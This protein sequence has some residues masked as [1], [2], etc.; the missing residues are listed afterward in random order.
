MTGRRIVRAL[1]AGGLL[2]PTLVAAG[3]GVRPSGVI[4][5]RSAVSGPAQG[6]G[7]YLIGQGELA[8]VLRPAKVAPPL[9]DVLALLAAG[10]EENERRQGLTS[11]VPAG[12][13]PV[14]VTS[15]PDQSDGLTV[16]TTTTARALSENAVDQIVC[17]VAD[18]A[19]QTGQTKSFV[20]V[21]IVGPD[22]A[23]SPR[24]C[25]IG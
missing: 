24:R 12:L 3:C 9:A 15:A 21:T 5:G 7:V 10:P 19:A 17:T 25:P 23:R 4:T 20:P 6:V 14:T 1:L 2:L 13:D 18:A 22:G 16:R 11:E 8:L